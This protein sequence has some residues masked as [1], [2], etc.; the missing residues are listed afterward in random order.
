ME[1]LMTM[2]ERQREAD[3]KHTRT[4]DVETVR[5]RL[6]AL[7]KVRGLMLIAWLTY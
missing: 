3:G 2:Y 5:E 6:Q 4:G 1:K 7:W